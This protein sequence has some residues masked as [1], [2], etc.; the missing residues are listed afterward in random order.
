LLDAQLAAQ[1]T[2]L[3]IEWARQ[4]AQSAS[5]GH[6]RTGVID[7]M[8]PVFLAAAKRNTPPANVTDDQAQKTWWMLTQLQEIFEPDLPGHLL[9]QIQDMQN[10]LNPEAIKTNAPDAP[11]P[12]TPN[13]STTSPAPRALVA[14]QSQPN[15]G[16]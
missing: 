9:E 14:P 15:P 3:A 5:V 10:Q 2:D 12:A 7:Q 1:N 16:G 4:M 13:A 11:D 8:V 6:D